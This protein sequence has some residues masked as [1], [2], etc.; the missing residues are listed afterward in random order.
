MQI[1]RDKSGLLERVMEFELFKGISSD[2][3]QWLIDQSE[4][5]IYNKGELIFEKGDPID[6]MVMCVDEEW[7]VKLEKNVALGKFGQME[8]RPQALSP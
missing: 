1:H 4:F 2:E 5:Q 6:H 3:L 8:I 7:V